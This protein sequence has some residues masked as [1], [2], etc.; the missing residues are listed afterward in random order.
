MPADVPGVTTEGQAPHGA[1]GGDPTFDSRDGATAD[2][3]ADQG[4]PTPSSV[5]PRGD[6]TGHDAPGAA[7]D[8]SGTVRAGNGGDPAQSAPAA[9]PG[10]PPGRRWVATAP[11]GAEPN[12]PV[13][14]RAT[15]VTDPT[16]TEPNGVPQP[17]A[18][19]NGVPQP[20]AEPGA[21]RHLAVPPGV[22]AEPPPAPV[23]PGGLAPRLPRPRLRARHAAARR[24]RASRR[25]LRVTQRL[26]SLDVWSVFK[27][28]ALFYL[29]MGLILLVAG[30]LLY[31][32]GRSIGTVDQFES[33]VTRMG[34]YGECVPKAEVASGT[35]FEEDDACGDGE[36]LVGGFTLDDGILFR[37]AAIGGAVLVVAGSIG[38]V[39][40]TVLLNLLN[41]AT[42]GLRH[43]VV[44]EPVKRPPGAGPGGPG[45]GRDPTTAPV[46]ARA[47]APGGVAGRARAGAP[48][49]GRRGPTGSP[50]PRVRR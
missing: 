18:E 44:R 1:G 33:F 20:E 12:G 16:V 6:E 10:S 21:G 17:E 3:L 48:G 46:R 41:E 43:T 26:W 35:E 19:P 34:A 5:P 23:L 4:L 50:P 40:I 29:C 24:D 14:P 9:G 36:V 49:D 47:G 25:G 7:P 30:T 8:T 37:V 22:G 32:A 42:G 15:T 28:S 11:P 38:N 39:L 31:N 13:S 2:A 27:I 45:P